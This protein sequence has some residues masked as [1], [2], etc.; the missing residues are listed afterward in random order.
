MFGLLSDINLMYDLCYLKADVPKTLLVLQFD[1]NP[2][3]LFDVIIFQNKKKYQ[4]LWSSSF[5]RCKTLIMGTV[6][7]CMGTNMASPYKALYIWVEHS[8]NNAQI[9]YRTNLNLD[10]ARLFI[11]Q[12]SFVPRFFELINFIECLWFL[13]LMA[14][15]CNPAIGKLL[16]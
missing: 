11:Y 4:S 12:S 2:W 5:I 10:M 7:I 9:N 6:P 14:W 13:F 8:P 3:F 16:C 1:T 15:H